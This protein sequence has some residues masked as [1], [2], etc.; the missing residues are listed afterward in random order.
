MKSTNEHFIKVTENTLTPISLE[1][2]AL[3]NRRGN[4]LFNKGLIQAAQRIFLTTGYSDGLTR[5]GDY[6][7]EH[8][9]IL[10]A[11]QMYCLAKNKR[12]SEPII[13]SLVQ[14][15]RTLVDIEKKE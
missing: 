5:V 15:I 3:L 13:D 1:Q 6:Y 4:E 14:L 9:N 8:N 7:F 2:K 12:K 10:E 11:L